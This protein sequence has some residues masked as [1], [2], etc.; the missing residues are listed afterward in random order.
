MRILKKIKLNKGMKRK[1]C[2]LLNP[3]EKKTIQNGKIEN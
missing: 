1:R 3:I 2:S